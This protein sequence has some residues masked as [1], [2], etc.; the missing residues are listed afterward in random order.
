MRPSLPHSIPK[1]FTDPVALAIAKTGIT[2][3]TLTLLGFLGN[4]GAAVL[5]AYGEFLAG[6]LVIL[7]AGGM[8]LLDGALARATGRASTF[9]AILDSVTDRLSEAAVLGGLL[10]YS[11]GQP[12]QPEVI[13]IYAALTGSILVSY[14]RARAE[15]VG[16]TLKEGLFTRAERVIL[17]AVGLIIDQVTIVLWL[18]AVLSNL[19]ALQRLFLCWQRTRLPQSAN[20]KSPGEGDGNSDSP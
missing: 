10:F 3:N 20:M 11:S 12:A 4:L 14:T 13:L 2:P 15:G 7:L 5:L 18:L 6:G 9:G 17:L 8:D 19:T 1:R 16:L